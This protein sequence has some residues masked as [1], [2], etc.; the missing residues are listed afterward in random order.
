[1][2]AFNDIAEYVNA[3]ECKVLN[4]YFNNLSWSIIKR[5]HCLWLAYVYFQRKPVNGLQ[6][7][8][9]FHH[10]VQIHRLTT[11]FVDLMAYQG[12]VTPKNAK[13]GSTMKKA[14]LAA[15]ENGSKSNSSMPG[16]TSNGNAIKRRLHT[17]DASENANSSTHHGIWDCKKC[18][19]LLT[20][21]IDPAAKVRHRW[22]TNHLPKKFLERFSIDSEGNNE[23][24][25]AAIGSIENAW[26]SCKSFDR[27]YI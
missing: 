14:I 22:A 26:S 8:R 25:S 9:H 2:S 23:S 20:A 27:Q 17:S 18:Q 11:P 15:G 24:S 7:R 6:W 21:K 16:Q 1:M 3:F 4:I 5:V 13:T 12:I 10:W 19:S